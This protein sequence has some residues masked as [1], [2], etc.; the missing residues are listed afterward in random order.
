MSSLARILDANVNRAREALRVMEDAARFVLEDLQLTAAIK[1]LRHDFA[2]ALKQLEN[3]EHNRDTPNDVGT[4]ISSDAEL[5]RD[6]I[7]HVVIAAGKRLSEALRSIEE[8]GKIVD[9]NFACAIEKLRYRGYDLEKQLNRMFGCGAIRQWRL[10]VILS[11]NLCGDRNWRDVAKLICDAEP[12]CIQLREKNISDEDL[13]DR[14]KT[15]VAMASQQTTIIINDRP[16]IA[17]LS[18]AHGVHLG[19]GD[20]PCAEARKLVGRQLIIGV[21]TSTIKEAEQARHDGADYCGVGP[22]FP[23]TTKHKD[24]IVGPEYLAQYLKWNKL[25]HLAIG[26]INVNN[27]QE[28]VEVGVKGVAVSS[29]ICTATEPQK[30]IDELQKAL[31]CKLIAQ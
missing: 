18:G 8:Y 27:I 22:M 13:L 1:Q 31:F 7:S 30:A 24:T 6:S 4:Q 11:E 2:Q 29:A 10:C 23:S 14:A 3:L 15:L 12:D 17:L 16:D 21:S 20:L 26:G 25:P 9:V 19:Q 28:L 5:K